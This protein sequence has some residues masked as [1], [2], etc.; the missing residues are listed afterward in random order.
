MTKD[1]RSQLAAAEAKLRDLYDKADRIAIENDQHC[2]ELIRAIADGCALESDLL[3]AQMQAELRQS[4]LK[5]AALVYEQEVFLPLQRR[6]RQLEID[7]LR[8][9]IARL[10]TEAAAAHTALDALL[11]RTDDDRRRLTATIA[12]TEDQSARLQRKLRQLLQSSS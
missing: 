4:L 3:A 8:A 9:E 6:V 10:N 12:G 2:K 1:L 11:T 7:D 5:K